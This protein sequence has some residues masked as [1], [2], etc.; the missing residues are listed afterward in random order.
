MNRALRADSALVQADGGEHGLI[1]AVFEDEAC[2]EG[3]AGD[4]ED[5]FGCAVV[6]VEGV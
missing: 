6:D 3:L 5:D 1:E 2:V 4:E